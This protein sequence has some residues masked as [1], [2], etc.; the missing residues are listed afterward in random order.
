MRPVLLFF[1][2]YLAALTV[3]AL[4]PFN[5]IEPL[6]L[7]L[8]LSFVWV[9]LWVVLGWLVLALRYLADRRNS[10]GS[11]FGNG[12]LQRA[13]TAETEIRPDPIQGR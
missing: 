5:R 8:P 12:G 7:G 10:I 13:R 2:V 6:V 3:P 4:Q 1:L 9:I 11:N